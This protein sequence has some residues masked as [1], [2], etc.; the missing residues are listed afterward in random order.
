MRIADIRRQSISLV[1]FGARALR[2]LCGRSSLLGACGLAR[3]VA[4]H[5]VY[6]FAVVAIGQAMAGEVVPEKAGAGIVD[7]G[8]VVVEGKFIGDCALEVVGAFFAAVGDLPGFFV[9]VAGD[10]GSRPEMAVAGNFSA[11]VEIVEH[12]ELQSQFVLVGRDVGAVHGQ[13]RVAV[14]D[15]LSPDFRSPRIWS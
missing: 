5:S 4:P 7:I 1:K 11:V 3:F 10:G 13:G 8:L 15:G 12:A 2:F 14:A 6:E 9:V